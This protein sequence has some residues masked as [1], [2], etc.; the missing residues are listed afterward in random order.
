M[1]SYEHAYA[2]ARA[3]G[4]AGWK[5]RLVPLMVDELIY[6]SLVIPDSAR[7]KAAV[8][9]LARG[10]SAGH[11]GDAH[12]RCGPSTGARACWRGERRPVTQTLRVASCYD[13][14]R[15]ACRPWV[16]SRSCRRVW[17]DSPPVN[18]VPLKYQN[19]ASGL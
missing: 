9:A 17:S 1:A 11:R 13:L 18:E 10:C 19:P 4:E 3:Y 2:L 7:R 16:Y 14:L 8:L 5:G 6:A 15:R 12:G